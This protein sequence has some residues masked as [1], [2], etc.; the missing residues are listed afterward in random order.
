MA[1]DMRFSEKLKDLKLILICNECGNTQDL[2]AFEVPLRCVY[3]QAQT[4][5]SD[6]VEFGGVHREHQDSHGRCANGD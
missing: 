2:T 4:K 5:V 3:C 6:P 1:P